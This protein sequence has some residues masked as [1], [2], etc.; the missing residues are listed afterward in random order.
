M[1]PPAKKAVP[2][3]PRGTKGS[4][5]K[6]CRHEGCEFQSKVQRE[7]RRREILYSHEINAKI[8]KD[9]IELDGHRCWLC[10]RLTKDGVWKNV[11]DSSVV[12][13]FETSHLHAQGSQHYVGCEEEEEE[14]EQEKQEDEEVDGDSSQQLEVVS[15]ATSTRAELLSSVLAGQERRLPDNIGDTRAILQELLLRDRE[16]EEENRALRMQVN[17]LHSSVVHRQRF[18][19]HQMKVAEQLSLLRDSVDALQC[20]MKALSQD[21]LSSLRTLSKFRQYQ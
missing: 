11:V 2:A 16:R 4:A 12:A 1:R 5:S 14:E 21:F 10:S 3:A 6:V 7:N 15:D 13:S 8:H 18:E 20:D 17:L 19:S 9:H